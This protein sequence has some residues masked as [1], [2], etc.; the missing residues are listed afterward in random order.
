[1]F[2][3][4]SQSLR[5]KAVVDRKWFRTQALESYRSL[6]RVINELTLDEITTCL[7]LEAGSLRRRSV[8]DRLIK[9]AVV[10]TTIAL[11]EKYLG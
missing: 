3:A 7:E 5:P 1:M 8:I 2:L 6:G 9:R 11:Q 10:L 4:M